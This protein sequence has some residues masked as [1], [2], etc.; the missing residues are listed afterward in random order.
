MYDALIQC[1]LLQYPDMVIEKRLDP[2]DCLLGMDELSGI[3]V[4]D[5]LSF[6]I[7]V[8]Q[9]EQDT[10]D[11]QDKKRNSGVLPVTPDWGEARRFFAHNL[12]F[13]FLIPRLVSAVQ[14]D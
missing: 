12:R 2:S 3:E 4:L 5:G 14:S 6:D 9:I 8:G 11:H 10:P 13:F 7:P 1:Q